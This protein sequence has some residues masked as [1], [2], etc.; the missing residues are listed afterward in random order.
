MLNL[1]SFGGK[2]MIQ[3]TRYNAVFVAI[4]FAFCAQGLIAE[5]SRDTLQLMAGT[6]V[7]NI[8]PAI[9]VKMGGY[10]N[11]TELSEGVHDSL[12]AR[13]VFF[14][15][16]GKKLVL[17]STDLLGFYNNTYDRIAA[18]VCEQ[19]ELKPS[20][21]F[22]SSIH[23]HSAPVLTFE[24]ESVHPNNLEYTRKFEGQ[25][26]ELIRM[27]QEQMLP[28]NIITGRGSSPVGVNRRQFNLDDSGWPKGEMVQ[29]G[30]NPSGITDPEVQVIRIS[31][32]KGESVA[33]LFGYA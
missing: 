25:I 10:G 15:Q 11:R 18:T 17:V 27:A 14:E 23:T 21:L 24:K 29:L 2:N 33:A 5:D 3:V 6:A 8:T 32:L 16:D 28:V 1:Q 26:V 7:V 19:L 30:R 4:L 31:G 20:E 13:A 9:P 12:Y 22:L